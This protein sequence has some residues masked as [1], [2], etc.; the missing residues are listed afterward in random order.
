[1]DKRKNPKQGY[2]LPGFKRRHPCRVP[3]MN[4]HNKQQAYIERLILENQE[5]RDRVAYLDEYVTRGVDP[6]FD[7]YRELEERVTKLE[8]IHHTH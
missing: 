3:S 4:M 1:M 8:D 5:L 6:I 7:Q 2:E